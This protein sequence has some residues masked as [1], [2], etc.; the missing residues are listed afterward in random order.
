[1]SESDN[2]TEIDGIAAE[3]VH[4]AET[5]GVDVDVVVNSIHKRVYDEVGRND[6]VQY[7]NVGSAAVNELERRLQADQSAEENDG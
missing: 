7:D 4:I 1:M 6:N 3:I 5:K 2:K